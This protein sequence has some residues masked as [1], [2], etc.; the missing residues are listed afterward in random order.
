MCL[1]DSIFDVVHVTVVTGILVRLH[2]YHS[3]LK[4]PNQFSGVCSHKMM[5]LCLFVIFDIM[6]M[7]KHMPS[8]V[9]LENWK[10]CG[11]KLA[12]VQF[13]VSQ[14][15][16]GSWNGTLRASG[17]MFAFNLGMWKWKYEMTITYGK[18]VSRW[19]YTPVMIPWRECL[20]VRMVDD[21][22]QNYSEDTRL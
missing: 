9:T 10:W 15:P 5:C 21:Q 18:L 11:T 12:F 3:T 20:P 14:I 17:S 4:C 1:C 22:W 19:F 16:T 6:D 2:V 7:T 8:T 13:V